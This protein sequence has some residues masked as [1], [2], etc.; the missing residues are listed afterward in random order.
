MAL[1][2]TSCLLLDFQW[3]KSIISLQIWWDF[4]SIWVSLSLL[5]WTTSKPQLGERL[6]PSTNWVDSPAIFRGCLESTGVRTYRLSL[7]SEDAPALWY[8]C[9]TR[10]KGGDYFPPYPQ[11]HRN[12]L[13]FRSWVPQELS[14]IWTLGRTGT[15]SILDPWS[16]IH[17]YGSEISKTLRDSPLAC[18]LWNLQTLRLT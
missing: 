3:W 9:L 14:Q 12:H 6:P 17:K 15:F 13:H 5:M 16:V 2:R 4:P 18:L 11:S 1:L 10:W 7:G 8:I